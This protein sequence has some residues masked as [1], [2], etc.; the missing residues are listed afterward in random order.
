MGFRIEFEKSDQ[1]V[2]IVDIDHFHASVNE[3]YP[4]D[5]F[6]IRCHSPIPGVV[7]LENTLKILESRC[8][9]IGVDII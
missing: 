1:G 2:Y 3:K 7:D 4:A 9:V 5:I 6:C 8:H